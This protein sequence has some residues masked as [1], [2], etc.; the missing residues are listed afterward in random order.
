M[1]V[2]LTLRSDITWADGEPV[3]ADDSVYSFELAGQAESPAVQRLH[4]RTQSYEAADDRTLVWTGVPGYRDSFCY[5]NFYRPFPR[6]IWGGAGIEDL[7]Q[8]E[9]AS[10]SPIG[11]GAFSV[12]EWQQGDHLTVVRSQ[13]YFRGSEGLPRVDR[14][15][16]RFVD[17]F[18]QAIDWLDKGACDV[19][20]QDLVEQADLGLL[21]EAAVAGRLEIV[22]SPSSEWE[23][24]DFGVGPAEG[25]DR[26]AFFEDSR[27]RQA[28]AMCIDRPG[29][30]REAVGLDGGIVA[31]S[32]VAPEHP[33]YAGEALTSWEYSPS[34]GQDM[35]EQVGWADE[36]GD[37]IRESSGVPGIRDGT[38]FSVTLLTTSGHSSRE[39]VAGL[40]STGLLECGVGVTVEAVAPEVFFADGPDGPVFG[41]RFDLALFSWL[42]GLDVPCS[43][44][45]SSEIPAP[46]NWWAVS[47][48]T[49]YA[50]EE[51]DRAC[52]RALNALPGTAE[53][54][55]YHTLSQRIFSREL[56][57]LPLYFVPKRLVVRPGVNGVVLDP[58]ESLEL[59]NIEE[60][61]VEPVSDG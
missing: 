36:D 6:H 35:L 54:A 9:A 7:M 38:P 13:T 12:E 15:T 61:D 5:L 8:S 60:F 4:D 10:R 59:W 2:T 58:G 37:G 25:D 48:D 30:V 3:T 50:S 34:Q 26:P 51:F 49:G 42:N 44:Y 1:A 53:N 40:I 18:S 16:F 19:I 20:S 17:S 23:H 22:T 33:S 28:V 41:R 39:S 27:V 56:P 24:L 47:N 21:T 45:L 55:R 31:N 11:W 29:L 43:L 46:Q 57:A 52:A 32:Y 14:I